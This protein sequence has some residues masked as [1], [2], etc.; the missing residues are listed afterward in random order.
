MCAI[1]QVLNASRRCK[2]T[3]RSA[4]TFMYF[5]CYE[6]HCRTKEI[7]LTPFAA[8]SIF[9]SIHLN[10]CWI[11][12]MH[13]WRRLVY[14]D[15]LVKGCYVPNVYCFWLWLDHTIYGVAGYSLYTYF[16]RPFPFLRKWVWPARLSR[17]LL[18]V[19]DTSCEILSLAS[20]VI[21]AKP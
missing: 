13:V 2:L 14:V 9:A 8:L 16:T 19:A 15:S 4:T 12:K 11:V 17:Q 21:S 10:S 1:Y 5:V 6:Q 20:I 18:T 3:I 7:Y